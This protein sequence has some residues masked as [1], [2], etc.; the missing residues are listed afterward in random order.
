MSM[1][2]MVWDT[3][4]VPFEVRPDK[5]KD[6]V[7]NHGWSLEPKAAAPAAPVETEAQTEQD[8]LAQIAG[9]PPADKPAG[10]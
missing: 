5:A 6:L 7:I 1:L 3:E 9:A 8:V 10:A 4:G 2:F